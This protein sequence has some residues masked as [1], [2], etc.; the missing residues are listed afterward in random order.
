MGISFYKRKQNSREDMGIAHC[1][2]GRQI[3]DTTS[4]FFYSYS[5][6]HKDSNK[7][8]L[9]KRSD[10]GLQH[11]QTTGRNSFYLTSAISIAVF[12]LKYQSPQVSCFRERKRI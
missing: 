2:E 8:S 10:S 6:K 11:S 5:F 7:Q 3:L 12:F 9:G 1:L 4:L